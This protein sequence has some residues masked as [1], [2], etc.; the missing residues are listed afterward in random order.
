M[1]PQVIV[2]ANDT[3]IQLTLD[4]GATVSIVGSSYLKRY[5]LHDTSENLCIWYKLP[6]ANTWQISCDFETQS[7]WVYG[8]PFH[9]KRWLQCPPQFSAASCL[10]LINMTDHVKD[11]D[12]KQHPTPV[13]PALPNH[14]VPPWPADA[15]ACGWQWVTSRTAPPPHPFCPKK[16]TRGRVGTATSTVHHWK[17]RR[18][19]AL[20]VVL[21]PKWCEGLRMCADMSC[22][23]KTICCERH[24]IPTV[25]NILTALNG[26]KLF[27]KLDLKE[28]YPQLKLPEDARSITTLP[29]PV[30]PFRYKQLNFAIN[31]ATVL[32]WD[33]IRQA[34]NNIP[35]LLSVSDV[36]PTHGA[37]KLNHNNAL[38]NMLESFSMFGITKSQEAQPFSTSPK[39]KF[40]ISP[41]FPGFPW[42]F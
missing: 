31:S 10:G 13:T 1:S 32:F 12:Q 26:A 33:T 15:P 40:Q 23:N 5:C 19:Q 36:I 14:T 37:T 35:H 25:D 24:F 29:T 39:M 11:T 6:I 22:A 18:T 38:K 34:I 21:A 20:S 2:K 8:R 9:C 30:G 27:L 28:K 4:T 17:N 16:A 41:A 3:P 42:N 7:L